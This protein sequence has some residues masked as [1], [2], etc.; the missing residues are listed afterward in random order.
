[1]APAAGTVSINGNNIDYNPAG[2]LDALD[3]GDTSI[4]SFTYEITNDDGTTDTALVTVTVTGVE[5]PLIANDDTATTD[6]DTPVSIAVLT[7]DS[8]PDDGFSITSVTN[9]TNGTV[10]INGAN[11]DFDPN[12]NFESL[13]AGDTAIE[14]FSYTITNDDG[15]TDVALVTVTITGVDDGLTV[16]VDPE[17]EESYSSMIYLQED[18]GNDVF[19]SYFISGLS[20]TLVELD[21]VTAIGSGAPHG[22]LNLDGDRLYVVDNDGGEVYRY[23]VTTG[24]YTQLITASLTIPSTNQVA[25]AEVDGVELLLIGRLSGDRIDAF[26]VSDIE[27]GVDTIFATYGNFPIVSGGSGSAGFFGGD[28]AVDEFGQVYTSNNFTRIDLDGNRSFQLASTSGGNGFGYDAREQA[29]FISGIGNDTEKFN[30]SGTSL[31]SFQPTLNGSPYSSTFGDMASDNNLRY[32]L[33]IAVSTGSSSPTSRIAQISFDFDNG[34]TPIAGDGLLYQGHIVNDGSL[35]QIS[36]N[37]GVKTARIDVDEVNQIW[38]VNFLV[39]SSGVDDN[40]QNNNVRIVN[41]ASD[42]ALKVSNAQQVDFDI[43]VTG[44]VSAP[45][46]SAITNQVSD[47]ETIEVNKAPTTANGMVSASID[48]VTPH[49]FSTSDFSFTDSDVGDTLQA[50]RVESLPTQG[51][52][53]FFD[54]VESIW[55]SL[56]VNDVITAAQMTSNEFRYN[57]TGVTTAGTFNFDFQVSDGRVWSPNATMDIDI[58]N[59]P[60][61][62]DLDDDDSSTVTGADYK[63]NFDV[64]ASTPVNITD[65]DVSITDQTDIQM[66]SATVT[67]TNLQDGADEVLAATGSGGITVNH[68]P[69]SG[70]LTLSGTA[71]IADYI[72]TLETLTYDNTSANPNTT[73]RSITIVVNDGTVDS[74][75]ATATVNILGTFTPAYIFNGP[76]AGGLAGE[77]IGLAGDFNGDDYSDFLIGAPNNDAGGAASSIRGEAYLVSGVEVPNEPGPEIE[78]GP[79]TPP[80]GFTMQGEADDELLGQSVAGGGDF[81]ADGYTDIIIGANQNGGL[82]EA[83]VLFGSSAGFTDP[84]GLPSS[85]TGSNGFAVSGINA[86]G[87]LSRVGNVG[88][89]NGDGLDDVGMGALLSDPNGVTNAGE[90]YVI[91]ATKDT[92]PSA[93]DLSSPTVTNHL[94]IQGVNQDGNLGRLIT[95]AGDVNNDGFDDIIIGAPELS[96]GGTISQAYVV[97]GSATGLLGSTLDVS[98]LNGTNGFS[99]TGIDPNDRLGRA[100][101]G[102][103]INGDGFSDIIIGASLANPNGNDSGQAY[104]IFGKASGFA[105]DIDPS[106]LNG[107]DGFRLNGIATGE[108]AGQSVAVVGD[109]NADGYNDFVVTARDGGPGG[110]GEAYLIFG[111]ADPF[112]ADIELSSLNGVRGLRLLSSVADSNRFGQWVNAAGDTNGDGFD[113]FIIA[114]READPNGADSGRT[115]LYYG[116]DY[117]N[118]VNHQGDN[119]NNTLTGAIG[120]IDERLNGAEG[121]DIIDG[122]GGNDIQIG[123]E[124]ADIIVFDAADTLRVDGGLGDDT[125]RIDG[126]GIT[127]DLTVLNNLIHTGFERIDITGAG[128]NTFKV[129]YDDVY[130]ITDE[131]LDELNDSNALVVD[132][133]AGDVV[134][135]DHIWA[136]A[137]NQ[138]VGGTLYDKYTF[139]NATLYI[140]PSIT[141]AFTVNLPPTTNPDTNTTDEDTVLNVPA[142]GVLSNDSDP[143]LDPITVSAFDA[144]SAQGAAVTVATDGSYTYDPSDAAAL[145]ALTASDTIVDTFTYTASDG[146]GTSVETVSITVTGLGDPPLIGDGSGGIEFQAVEQASLLEQIW[147]V[148]NNGNDIF[149]D[150]TSG[151][152][153]VSEAVDTSGQAAQA[154]YTDPASGL[155]RL[156]S[157]GLE[158]YNGQTHNQVAGATGL[159]GDQH[160]IEGVLI[161]AKPGTTDEFYVVTNDIDVSAS[162]GSGIFVTTVDLSMG[163]DGTVTSLNAAIAN[164]GGAG[165]AL[166][167]VPHSNGKDVWLLV[168][169]TQSNIRSYLITE[170]GISTTPVVSTTN[171]AGGA[172]VG[173]GV[174]VHTEDFDTLGISMAGSSSGN[175]DNYILTASIDRSTGAVSSFTTVASGIEVGGSIAFSPDGSILYA[176]VGSEGLNGDPTQFLL[177]PNTSNA[178]TSTN[179]SGIMLASDGKVYL[180][181]SGQSEF[182]I[183][184]N[185]NV[186]GAGANFEEY[187]LDLTTGRGGSN[188]MNQAAA[189]TDLFN[190]SNL[191]GRIFLFSEVNTTPA[192]IDTYVSITDPDSVNFDTGNLSITYIAG[193]GAEDSLSI[194]DEGVAAGQIGFNGATVTYG[195]VTIGSINGAN[196]GSNG[197]DLIVDFNSNATPV[198][199]TA[200]IQNITYAN[201]SSIPTL[202]R[203]IQLTVTDDTGISDSDTAIIRVIDDIPALDLD[204]DDSS[205]VIGSD[206][207]ATFIVEDGSPVGITDSDVSITDNNDTLIQSATVTITNQLDGTSEVL[208]ADTTGTSITAVYTP[209]TGLLSLTGGDTLANYQTVLATVTYDNTA[210]SPDTTSRVITF[211]VNDGATDSNTATTTLNYVAS[212]EADYVFNGAEGNDLA[213]QSLGLAG[214]YNGDD[215]SDF[216][217]GANQADGNTGNNAGEAYLISGIDVE[218][219][220]GEAELNSLSSPL[221]FSIFG[222]NDDDEIGYSVNGGGDFNGD[223]YTDLVIGAP[224]EDS[225]RGKSFILFGNASGFVDPTVVE[226]NLTGANGFYIS[227]DSSSD[228]FGWSVANAGDMNGDGLDEF[229]IGATESDPGGNNRG[230]AYVVFGT[231]VAMPNPYDLSSPT[232][233]NHLSIRGNNNGAKLGQA[234][235]SVGDINNDGYEDVAVSQIESNNG[236]VFVVFGAAGGL[237]GSTIATNSLNGSNGFGMQGIDSGDRFGLSISGGGDF[238][239]DGIADMII[240]ADEA[241]VNGGNSGQAYVIFGKS[242]AFGATLDVTTLNGSDGFRINGPTG[243]DLAG[244]GVSFVGDYNGDGYDDI[245]VTVPNFGY[246]NND[247]LAYLIFGSASGMPADIELSDFSGQRGIILKSTLSDVQAFGARVSAAGD[248]NGDGFDD[249]TISDIDA[250][251]NGGSS[252]RV[253]LFLG[254]DQFGDVDFQGDNTANTLT[255]TGDSEILNG[256]QGDDTLDGGAGND[257]LIGAE[258]DDVLIFDAADTLRVDGGLGN[259]TLQVNGSGVTVNLEAIGDNIISGVEIIDL[260]GSG[261]NTLN[262]GSM[263]VYRISDEGHSDVNNNNA[264]VVKGNSGDAVTS[265]ESWTQGG[266]QV[267]DSVTYDIFTVNNATLFIDQNI[268][269]TGL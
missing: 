28:L 116:Q 184:H 258:G 211:V 152:P 22:A 67:I 156:Y 45:N 260:T 96:S 166:D 251:P 27:A 142:P 19:Y 220:V 254:Q 243:S 69:G 203:T 68:V 246:G 216:L 89:V 103:D 144:L 236:N 66:S 50:I 186:F 10:S 44:F 14:S 261:N 112:P 170:S 3:V 255:G 39:D 257:V 34:G 58:P 180:S 177:G 205:G 75:I 188:I 155:L 162:T 8:D 201:S 60:P 181:D 117:F 59:S 221:G 118:E 15:V 195:G 36:T 122:R 219:I 172:D 229:I 126:S 223:G 198:A 212:I 86:G 171:V 31:G 127:L 84:L 4:Q 29:L 190:S 20:G 43:V 173:T 234:V 131:G 13:D 199:V 71:D 239:G 207:K 113:D 259:D 124:G 175:S 187:G 97:F 121:D 1:T 185:P 54:N 168:M 136:A 167:A 25:V 217:I 102:G 248:V 26:R 240:G 129:N 49:I 183:V 110:N 7:N 164:T 253:M 151:V 225:S 47:T 32:L 101:D 61:V 218:N 268:D 41:N 165:E 79:M 250:A 48:P 76:D 176:L 42:F 90:A 30:K 115:F 179:H 210:V 230:E 191:D 189:P 23:N 11:I 64:D 194:R 73:P 174:I 145:Q 237:P 70:V 120:V 252:G 111:S 244:T 9:P 65:I 98:T 206:F 226:S 56:T 57:P 81:N 141:I 138:L 125:L 238:N 78:L 37:D 137:G 169:D 214:D 209:A 132:G 2:A 222:D 119:T 149:V 85:L 197:A 266:T 82:G 267:I 63:V 235:T 100:I 262:I 143:N 146:V 17:T 52:L 227:G 72:A 182:S 157:D 130:D 87:I 62:L 232:V 241:N 193:G 249:L 105:A 200:L 139:N 55:F 106:A 233:T 128:N 245:V 88:D 147:Y 148:G 6:E 114:D 213:G 83:Y 264:L 24:S 46:S 40:T 242:T 94:T 16:S 77:T 51:T 134:D 150:F 265:T 92:M 18:G 153:V 256:A 192:V 228:L 35:I 208:A 135:S 80:L 38:T 247:G 269:T 133:N 263:D 107:T 109:V 204:N 159:N 123:G 5:D 178:L 74:N 53:E 12:G 215:Y 163:P 91:F 99:I 108:N 196:N 95:S 231:S 154:S 160:T 21:T 104:V 224:L 93:Y 33:P 161:I 140:H 202:N 158:I